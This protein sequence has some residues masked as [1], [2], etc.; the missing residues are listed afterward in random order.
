MFKCE[1]CKVRL[2]D[3]RL[4]GLCKK[5][6]RK[7]R[8]CSLVSPVPRVPRVPFSYSGENRF[9]FRK[10]REGSIRLMRLSFGHDLFQIKWNVL[11]LTPS[12]LNHRHVSLDYVQKKTETSVEFG[13]LGFIWSPLE[14][15]GGRRSGFISFTATVSWDCCFHCVCLWEPLANLVRPAT[16]TSLSTLHLP[17]VLERW[18]YDYNIISR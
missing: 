6:K 16:G 17:H 15:A 2:T 10:K 8:N 7:C 1:F 5:H 13:L 11:S 9:P 18:R 12:S 4:L 14:S 3:R